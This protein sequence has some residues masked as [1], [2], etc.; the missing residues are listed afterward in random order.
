MK[1]LLKSN[2]TLIILIC[3]CYP[4]QY[5]LTRSEFAG[6]N[7]LDITIIIST[8]I[9]RMVSRMPSYHQNLIGTL[10]H[11]NISQYRMDPNIMNQ[12]TNPYIMNQCINHQYIMNY[13][14]KNYHIMNQ[15]T[16]FHAIAFTFPATRARHTY[17][18]VLC[19]TFR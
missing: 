9:T 10:Y 3:S 17:L 11:T 13:N 6:R 16:V 8:M 15:H 2:W 18:K 12:C 14:I 4:H 19:N 1:R 7:C 5:R